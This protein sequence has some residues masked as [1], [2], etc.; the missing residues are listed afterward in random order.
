MKFGL[1][2]G[3]RGVAGEADSLR[4]IAQTAEAL[5]YEHFGMS[6]HVV[7]ATDATEVAASTPMAWLATGLQVSPWGVSTAFMSTS[8]QR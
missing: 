4:T 3:S 1:H 2:F 8:F 5:G 7:V 6:D